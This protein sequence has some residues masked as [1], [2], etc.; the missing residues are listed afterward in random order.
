MA[1]INISIRKEVYDRL[2]LLKGPE[3]S[4]SDV[5]DRLVGRD[6]D[7]MRNFGIWKDL[8]DDIWE[9]FEQGFKKARESAQKANVRFFEIWGDNP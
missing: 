1:S 3:E 2:K 7:P 6:K 9:V 4:F 8:P 5:I